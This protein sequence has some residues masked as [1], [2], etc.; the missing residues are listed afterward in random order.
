M[1]APKTSYK[2]VKSIVEEDLGAP[3]DS[4]FSEF[5]ESPIA[6]ASLA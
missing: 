6:S 3:I 2:D 1:Q 5:A 4:M